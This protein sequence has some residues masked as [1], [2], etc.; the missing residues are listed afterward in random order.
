MKVYII[1]LQVFFGY[2]MVIIGCL[3]ILIGGKNLPVETHWNNLKKGLY[4]TVYDYENDRIFFEDSYGNK[5][6]EFNRRH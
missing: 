2:L 6:V 4:K 3:L 5:V 1:Y